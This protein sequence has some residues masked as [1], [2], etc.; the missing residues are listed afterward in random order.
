[1]SAQFIKRHCRLNEVAEG[2]MKIATT[3]SAPT[4]ASSSGLRHLPTLATS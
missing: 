4:T 2:I 1:M 3:V